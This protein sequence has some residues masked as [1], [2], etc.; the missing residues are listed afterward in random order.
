MADWA[1]EDLRKAQLPDG[2]AHGLLV[3]TVGHLQRRDPRLAEL[4]L[5]WASVV[6]GLHSGPRK[7]PWLQELQRRVALASIDG[8]ARQDLSRGKQKPGTRWPWR[9]A[10]V[11]FVEGEFRSFLQ[12]QPKATEA[13]LTAHLTPVWRDFLHQKGPLPPELVRRMQ[14]AKTSQTA[15]REMVARAEGV[16]VESL[17]QNTLPILRKFRQEFRQV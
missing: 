11:M 17:R 10:I 8:F 16:D 1:L 9:A 4:V 6:G 12:A 13:Q 2:A 3:A 15:A 5:H 14:R 7:P